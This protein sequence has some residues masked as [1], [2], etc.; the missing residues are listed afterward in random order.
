MSMS[1]LP[2][3]IKLKK[4]AELYVLKRADLEVATDIIN[5]SMLNASLGENADMWS[6]KS[7]GSTKL[8]MKLTKFHTSVSKQN[9]ITKKCY[10]HFKH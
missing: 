5:K 9:K 1:N 3:K 4:I 8:C 6:F 7:W 10:F 2:L